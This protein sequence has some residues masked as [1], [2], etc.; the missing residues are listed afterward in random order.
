MVEAFT[1]RDPQRVQVESEEPSGRRHSRRELTRQALDEVLID[2]RR[3]DYRASHSLASICFVSIGRH[4]QKH[5]FAVRADLIP[6]GDRHPTDRGVSL[7]GRH[8][9]EFVHR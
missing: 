5:S 3:N 7:V 8:G 2:L 1:D 9:F 4:G 6:F